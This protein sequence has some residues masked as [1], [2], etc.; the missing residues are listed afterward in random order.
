MTCGR[1]A[2]EIAC[3]MMSMPPTSVDVRML[4]AAPSAS[5]CVVKS[6]GASASARVSAHKQPPP[7]AT[8]LPGYLERKLARGR[9]HQRKERLWLVEQGLAAVQARGVRRST[10]RAALLQAHLQDGEREGT[11][12]AGARLRQPNYVFACADVYIA[13]VR[14]PVQ[15]R[16]AWQHGQ[17]AHPP[18]PAA[19]PGAGF[20]WALSSPAPRTPALAPRIRQAP[21]RLLQP[22]RRQPPL[23]AA[24]CERAASRLRCACKANARLRGAW[25]ATSVWARPYRRFVGAKSACATMSWR[26]VQLFK[27]LPLPCASSARLPTFP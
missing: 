23:L 17:R 5:N 2:S 14:G 16:R 1:L 12:F 11:G 3:A 13:G 10:V 25:I 21:E 24:G 26:P 8:C 19:P 7:L 4:M 22:P 20:R 6:V 27:G 15:G 9:Q 18:R